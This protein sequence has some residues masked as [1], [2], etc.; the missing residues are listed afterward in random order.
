M[1]QATAV[2]V[3]PP[4]AP[5]GTREATT[6]RR[7]LP[8]V[9]ALRALAV[10][11][12]VAYHLRPDLLT[13]GFVGVDVFFVISGFLITGH[14]VREVRSTGRVDL[15]RFWAARA[16]R[17]L[18][19]GLL[20]LAVVTAVATFVYPVTAWAGLARQAL[21]SVLYVQNWVLAADSV[22][23]LALDDAP[24]VYQHFWSLAV[25]EQFYLLWPLL[26]AGVAAAVAARRAHGPALTRG[27]LAVFG[28]VVAASFVWNVVEVAQ[29]DASAYFSTFTRLW[30]LGAGGMLALGVRYTDAHALPRALLA[31][32]GVSAIVVAAVTFD[33][34]TP[35]PG[36]A[37]LVPVL[38]TAAVIAAGRTRGPASLT[39]LVDLGPVR[40]LG[41]LSYS[42]YLWH[43]PVIVL[44]T[45]HAGRTPTLMEAAGLLGLSLLLAAATFELVEQP[46]RRASGLR[47][48]PWR[49]LGLA[50]GAMVLV[51]LLTLVY[52]VRTHQ[53]EAAWS[54]GSVE[55]G[56]GSGFGAEA[57]DGGAPRAFVHGTRAI[58]PSPVDAPADLSALVDEEA[59]AAHQRETSARTCEVGDPAATTVVA[60]VGDSHA[61]MLATPLAQLAE[62]QGW[63]LVTYLHDSC[64]YSHERRIIE[65]EG[66][67]VC[68]EPNARTLDALLALRPALVVTSSYAAGEYVDTGTG[69]TPGAVGLAGAWDE[70][71]DAGIEV[72]AV[73]DAPR[74]RRDVVRCT[75]EHVDDP[76]A[77]A[78]DRSDAVTD[79]AAFDEAVR[80]SPRTTALDLTDRYCGPS[81][82]PPVIGNVLV[83]RDTNH[84]TDTF[85]RSLAPDL[86]AAVG[87][88][89]ETDEG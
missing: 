22:D 51:A 76:D 33:G 25:E 4:D 63:R 48:R 45:V 38:G 18:P 82:C 56:P 26:V 24:T 39:P 8:E 17:I 3:T 80:L 84:I 2:R 81:S 19:A 43:F 1:G 70:L 55:V 77:C 49:T 47:E 44:Y 58:V 52:P 64:P 14:M 6:A 71:A 68:Q 41:D 16:R 62:Q 23:Y 50:A 85:A 34:A 46:A 36:P 54:G 37:A 61:Q 10:G 32:A 86:A 40:R 28:A 27:L 87:A 35:F 83:Y 88:L 21:A 57:S 13:G 69:H 74:P 9:Q 66:K 67:L 20:V 72:L 42:L 53:V 15:A 75:A 7:F 89:V 30:E 59:C 31:L 79:H 5:T 65:A 60:L 29:G 78:V 12:V 11:I 73:K